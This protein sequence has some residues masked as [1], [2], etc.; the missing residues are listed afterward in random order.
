MDES[1]AFMVFLSFI[2]I[3][4]AIAIIVVHSYLM[5]KRLNDIVTKLNLVVDS[6]YD[7]TTYNNKKY[8]SLR[9]NRIGYGRNS[10]NGNIN[11]YFLKVSK[12][13]GITSEKEIMIKYKTIFSIT[14]AVPKP[15]KKTESKKIQPAAIPLQTEAPRAIEPVETIPT[16]PIPKSQFLKKQMRLDNSNK[17][18]YRTDAIKKVKFN[19]CNIAPANSKTYSQLPLDKCKDLN[20]IFNTFYLQQNRIIEFLT[21]PSKN[22]AILKDYAQ[23]NKTHENINQ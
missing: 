2:P 20:P 3:A 10:K 18:A 14:P 15:S 16:L 11:L 6:L 17:F 21:L 23:Q 5:Q 9:F 8:Y 13:N 7:I 1:Y 19:Y 12:Y 4:I 22:K